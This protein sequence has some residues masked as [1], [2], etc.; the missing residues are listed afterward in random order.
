MKVVCDAC[1]AKYQIPDERVAGRKLKIRCRKC[2][3]TITVRG[4]HDVAGATSSPREA[5]HE[6]TPW[7][8]SLDGEQHGP[9]ASEQMANML[10]AGQLPWDAHV[11]R[12]GYSDWKT[13]AESDTLVRA[14]AVAGDEAPTMAV[15]HPSAPPTDPSYAPAFTGEDT[16]ARML[17]SSPS[18]A[19]TLQPSARSA[20]AA[21]SAARASQP[22]H[23][24]A[25][26]LGSSPALEQTHPSQPPEMYAQQA[27]GFD[28]APTFSSARP[29]QLTGERNE[30]SVLFSARSLSM[31]GASAP[32]QPRG[33]FA[34]GEGS[35]L[36]DIRAL[37]ALARG[38]AQDA[39]TP[40]PLPGNGGSGRPPRDET[41]VLASQTGAFGNLD[42]LAPIDRPSTRPNKAVPF[43]ILAGSGMIAVAAVAAVYLLRPQPA[44]TRVAVAAPVAPVAEPAAAPQAALPSEPAPAATEPA[45]Q[46]QQ[47]AAAPEAEPEPAAEP[48]HA[49]KPVR[50][51]NVR[52]ARAA[53]A[54]SA[55]V[56][57]AK[58]APKDALEDAVADNAKVAKKEPSPSI[59]DL[60]G[61]KKPAA[62][63][64]PTKSPAPDPLAD[65]TP[66][67]KPKE[68]ARSRSID[69]LLDDAVPGKNGAAAPE[70]A[71]ASAALPEAPTRDQ[72]LAAM[73]G[74]EPAVQACAEGQTLEASSA[75]VS[76]TVIGFTGK[77]SSVRVNGVGGS[78]GSCIARAVR[79][80]GFPKFAKANFSI[81]FPFKLQK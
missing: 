37:A 47:P 1:Q 3:A 61:D 35:G 16:P 77:V 41:L 19:E 50:V 69:E 66:L 5:A 64:E 40:V 48:V 18:L 49:S 80:A 28:S 74:V 26:S 63:A 70:A 21:R 71:A 56:A 67:P 31:P 57:K 12:E 2:G 23:A 68:P 43:A 7:H 76:I 14:V 44:P 51:A 46:A 42:S 33:G 60:L 15:A 38:G 29:V 25:A 78:V 11:W 17:Q 75:T 79:G 55:K 58:P 54:V 39:T 6:Q 9:Y 36:I 65:D 62:K 13:A 73:H 53:A 32:P 20:F 34:G 8:V 30:D 72:V 27:R 22:P 4:D 10:R 24:F 52:H 59:D 45:P 81:N